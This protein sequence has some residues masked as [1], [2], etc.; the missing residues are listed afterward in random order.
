MLVRTQG[1]LAQ[2]LRFFLVGVIETAQAGIATL[3]AILKLQK[4]AEAQIET[5]GSRA[6][7][8]HRVLS[9]LF[10]SPVVDAAKVAKIAGVSAASAYK[11]VADLERLGILKEITGGRR[12]RT[13][14]FEAYVKLFR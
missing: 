13:Y 12:G 10:K 6:A 7:N 14:I 2:W 11:L 1:D 9:A 4:R 3:D 5:L 8:A